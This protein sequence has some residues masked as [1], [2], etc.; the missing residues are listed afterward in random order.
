MLNAVNKHTKR[1]IIIHL[2]VLHHALMTIRKSS[3]WVCLITKTYYTLIPLLTETFFY[4]R[5]S[6]LNV[7]LPQIDKTSKL[8]LV[9]VVVYHNSCETP[10]ALPIQNWHQNG[11]L[12]RV[13]IPLNVSPRAKSTALR[14]LI[15]DMQGPKSK[16][17]RVV[18]RYSNN[19]S[20]FPWVH[21]DT[22]RSLIRSQ[23][24]IIEQLWWEF[25][26]PWPTGFAV[27]VRIE[28]RQSKATFKSFD[29]KFVPEEGEAKFYVTSCLNSSS[30]NLLLHQHQVK[31]ENNQ[32]RR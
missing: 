29:T 21:T 6:W 13:W 9:I 1:C 20:A 2:S 8:W 14:S 5:C 25:I 28:K 18:H 10:T 30:V 7:I 23:G 19:R 32:Y 27:N 24:W 3:R 22:A 15:K 12:H 31:S 4:L 11:T 16:R 17:P 26:T